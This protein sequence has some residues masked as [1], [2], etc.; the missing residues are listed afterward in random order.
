MNETNRQSI[1]NL[2]IDNLNRRRQFRSSL[3]IKRFRRLVRYR[4]LR[5]LTKT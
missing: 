2:W 4:K 3:T 5:I 1:Q